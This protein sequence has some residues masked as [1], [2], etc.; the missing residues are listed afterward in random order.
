MLTGLFTIIHVMVC[1]GL[2]LIILLQAGKGAGMGAAF[3]GAS[4]TLFGSTGRASFM[5]K[6]TIVA[7]VVFC[8]TSLA[9]SFMRSQKGGVMD[10]YKPGEETLPGQPKVPPAT[11]PEPSAGLT[12]V[13]PGA[14]GMVPGATSAGA[15]PPASPGAGP[16]N[17]P[18]LEIPTGPAPTSPPS[19]PTP[20]PSPRPG[21]EKPATSS[22]ARPSPAHAAPATPAPVPP[23]TTPAPAGNQKPGPATPAPPP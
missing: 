17:I 12:A 22:P 15:T 5:T 8:F 23:A 10:N 3:G 4:Q 2:I 13:P 7:A 16:A 9:L 18:G 14:P 19:T 11:S 6:I 20:G 21:T 1:V